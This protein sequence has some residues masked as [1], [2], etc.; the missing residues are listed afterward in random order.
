[1][2]TQYA[3]ALVDYLRRVRGVQQVVVAGSYRRMKDTVG[4]LDILVTAQSAASGDGA[5]RRL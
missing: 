1:M 2:A 5:L 3:E 4:D